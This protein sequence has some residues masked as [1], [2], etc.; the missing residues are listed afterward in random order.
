VAEGIRTAAEL[1]EMVQD[2]LEFD[3]FVF[4]V[5]TKGPYRGN[6][7]RND[8][9]WISLAGPGR[10]DVIPCGHPIGERV[11]YDVDDE[12]HRI[13]PSNNHY[14]EHRI[15]ETSGRL[16]WF[17]I[18]PQ[19]T[20]APRQLWISDV[21]DALAELMFSDRRKIGHNVKFD[22]RSLAKYYDGAMPPGPYGDTVVA[23]R[24]VNENHHGY[25]LGDCV[26]REFR[27]QYEKIGKAGPENF[28]YSEARLY[29]YLDSKYDW[30]LWQKL[31][32]RLDKQKVRHI[33]DME[34]DLLPAI[35]DMEQTGT[36]I[37]EVVL[38]DLGRE[39]MTEMAKHKIAINDAA[40]FDI[41]LNANRQVAEL[42]YETLGHKCTVF[43]EKTQQPSTAAATLE[44]F[45]KDPVIAHIQEHAKLSKLQST[46]IEG[47]TRNTFEGRVHPSFNQV[48]AVSGRMSCSEPNIQQIPS[49]TERGKRIREV[50]IAGPKNVLVVADL[51]QIELRVLAHFTQDPVLLTAYRNNVDLHGLLA[52]RVF[53]KE[54]TP[55]DRSLAKNG[56]FCVPMDTEALT[57][58]GWKTYDEL[59]TDDKVAAY[60]NGV[61]EWTPVL[62][63]MKFDDAP[64]IQMENNHFKAISTPNHRW[65]GEHRRMLGHGK[66]AERFW[67]R[68]EITTQ[69]FMSEDRIFLSAPLQAVCN[70]PIS[71]DEAAL[72]AWLWCDGHIERGTFVG[73][74]SQSKGTKVKFFS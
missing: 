2:Y 65:I 8:V 67:E 63:K 12:T 38:S 56:N 27:Y 24:L 22:I 28:P 61:L 23:A 51:S 7:Y 74:P 1:K 72:V 54:Y 11:Y 35:I 48:G 66:N 50:F 71:A 4:D 34:M 37:D 62:E 73:A 13:N 33:F 64:L 69:S 40:G 44:A 46:F 20:P 70:L 30:L 3:E 41:N 6:P 9:F 32:P 18:P 68:R 19:F 60:K 53:G 55:F 25:R 5:E 47:I 10:A 45:S 15:N 52:R 31:K 29:S 26:K 21:A 49:R 58:E 16:K 43:S 36:P 59:S 42:V 17:D 57:L 39:F 14:Q